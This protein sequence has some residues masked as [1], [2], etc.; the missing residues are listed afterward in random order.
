MFGVPNEKGRQEILNIHTRNMPMDK[1]VDLPYISKI[2]HGFV[3]ADIESLI[4]EAAMNVI[5]RNINELNIKEGNNIPKAVL[6]KLTVTMDDFREALRFVRPSAMREVLVERP[7]VGW[8]DV[9][10]LGEVKDHLKEAIDW[11]IKHPDS[12]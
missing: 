11:P 9:G 3:G 8:N 12:F 7:S 4:K 5:R 10:G 2:T 1:S 6:E